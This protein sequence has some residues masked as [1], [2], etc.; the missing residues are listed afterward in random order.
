MYTIT[1]FGHVIDASGTRHDPSKVL[2]SIDCPFPKDAQQLRSC[3]E[4]GN[5][6]GNVV[7]NMSTAAGSLCFLTNKNV[8]YNWRTTHQAAFDALKQSLISEKVLAHYD[9]N[10]RIGVAADASAYGI[11][12]VLFHIES[13]GIER[14]VYYVN[15][16]LSDAEKNYFQ[17]EKEGLAIIF[18]IKLFNCYITGRHFVLFTDHRPLLKIF[19]PNEQTPTTT[20]ARLQR[21]ALFLGKFDNQ[22]ATRS[23]PITPMITDCRVIRLR[24]KKL[25]TRRYQ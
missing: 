14:P 9:P 4:I 25:W 22:S 3:L 24:R 1:Y 23:R 6:Y 12:A 21:L 2:A 13:N 11:G 18:A 19:G 16:V 7:P 15:R 17:I 5:Y 20:S 8:G 10:K